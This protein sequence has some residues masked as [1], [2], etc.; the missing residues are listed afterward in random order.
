MFEGYCGMGSP[1]S[2]RYYSPLPVWAAG[3]VYLGGAKPR[4]GEQNAVISGAKAEVRLEEKDGKLTVVTNLSEIMPKT[5]CR[6]ISTPDLGTAFEPEQPFE[7]HDG[8]PITFDTDFF[9]AKRTGPVLPG[10]F[11]SIENR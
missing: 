9:G 3:N 11:A 8:T 6:L 1:A 4:K 7:A 2:D 10:P 5:T